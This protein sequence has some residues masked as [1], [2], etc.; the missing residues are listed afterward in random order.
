[1]NK[2]INILL[3]ICINVLTIETLYLNTTS[4]DT[5]TTVEDIITSIQT[6]IE[7]TIEPTKPVN[8][9]YNAKCIRDFQCEDENMICT[10]LDRIQRCKCAFGYGYQSGR[11]IPFDSDEF[12]CKKYVDCQDADKNRFCNDVGKCRCFSG[13]S[14]N[15]IGKC[16]G[17]AKL[18][19]SCFY[20]HSCNTP[21]SYCSLSSKCVCDDRYIKQSNICVRKSCLIDYDCREM[22]NFKCINS[23]HC[24]CAF[25]GYYFY[26]NSNRGD[27]YCLNAVPEEMST[28]I[29]LGWI[30][31]IPVLILICC[32][33]TCAKQKPREV[34]YGWVLVAVSRK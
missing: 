22:N 5:L 14:L 17:S 1:M 28:G 21:F 24:D 8:N 32:C 6:T 4:N 31:G 3:L 23:S 29:L 34:M 26:Y 9:K 30:I 10:T 16:V 19:D 25:P 13:L 33:A 27:G 11:C 18:G 2:F 12:K 7:P 15:S 20:H